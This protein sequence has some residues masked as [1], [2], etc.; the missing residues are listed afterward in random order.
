MLKDD[1]K[2]TTLRGPNIDVEA[3]STNLFSR[4]QTRALQHPT[5]LAIVL[6]DQSI[7]YAELYSL[8]TSFASRLLQVVHPGDIVCQCVER[9]IE[10]VVGI[11]AI[12][13]CN[14]V[15]CPLSP[16]DP[17]ER[18]RSLLNET[19][20]KVI[21]VHQATNHLF[22][23]D[24]GIDYIKLRIDEQENIESVPNVMITQELASLAFVVFTSGSTGTPKGVPIGHDNFAYYIASMC[25]EKYILANDIILQISQDTFDAHLQEILGAVLVGGTCIL[26]RSS[27]GAHLN[28]AYLTQ[29]M[30]QHQVTFT[31]LVPSLAIA[32]IDY[33]S[34]LEQRFSPSL[35]LVISTG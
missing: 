11:L 21:L 4:F 22:S 1:I 31:N 13:L 25:H 18:H 6:D 28:T 33:L 14:T 10:M 27:S 2:V 32:L 23:D 20:A 17:L 8:V 5:K 12:F 26:L 3:P 15:Y 30:Y 24:D 19:R 16:K 9:S 7:S 35:R 34:R 29:T